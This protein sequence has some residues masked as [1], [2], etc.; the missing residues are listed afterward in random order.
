[1]P[2]HTHAAHD[3]AW[4]IQQTDFAGSS[5]KAYEGLFAQGAPGLHI[6]GSLEEPIAD[7][8]QGLR[9]WRTPGNVTAE[10]FR[11]ARS[12]FG[13]YLPGIYGSHP[14]L[15]NELVNLPW[16][17]W[18]VPE[19][20]GSALDADSDAVAE[21]ERTLDLRDNTLVR[22]L[23]W[24]TPGGARVSLLYER[25]VSM[26]AGARGVR[27]CVQRLTID[28]D[29]ATDV[30]VRAGIDADV[31]TNG[32]DHFKRV[33]LAAEGERVR[34]AVQTD[35]GDRVEIE[36]ILLA[37]HAAEAHAE[38]RRGWSEARAQVTPG[39]PLV[40]EK[41]TTVTTS[42]DAPDGGGTGELLEAFAGAGFD[43][44]HRAH[45]D[46]WR[47]KWAHADVRIQ[48]DDRAQLAVRTSIAHLLRTL[49]HASD[50]VAI[51]A[52]GYAG[53]AYWGRFFWDTE[54]YLLPF[55]LYTDPA[56]ARALADFRIH[57]LEGAQRNAHKLGLP[58][59]KYAW[60]SDQLGDECCPN[61]QYADHEVHITSDVVYGL[62]HV[63]RATGDDSYLDTHA[64]CVL[65][66]AARYW[67]ARVSVRPGDDHPSILGVM[68]PDEYTPI[69]DNNAYTNRLASFALEA[70]ADA[71]A[72]TGQ[73]RDEARTWR[74]LGRTLPIHRRADGLVL[75]SD[76]FD[77]LPLADFDGRWKD[78]TRPFASQAPQEYLYR[79]QCLKQADV[80]M[81]MWLFDSEFSIED[82]RTA[83]RYYEPRTTHDSSLSAAI[84]SMMAC[85][86]GLNEE[87]WRFWEEACAID[88]DGGA[89]EG[90]HIAACGAVWQMVV[91]GFA[92]MRSAMEDEVLTLDP[93]LPAGWTTLEF[94]LVWRG[95]SVQVRVTKDGV[96]LRHSGAASLSARVAGEL[97]EIPAGGVG[98]WA[99]GGTTAP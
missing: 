25:F 67:T 30:T 69:A 15:N 65:F 98:R 43:D 24:R 79:T 6:R 23:T 17:L 55:Y 9:Y 94:P 81:L 45:A 46:A 82:Q 54:M 63:A 37:P 18:L 83:W 80:L 32:Y 10:V 26:D 1:M 73:C 92:G 56:G 88:L 49:P 27:L 31:T 2:C 90:I 12:K 59:A 33:D 53:E 93:R 52:K 89:A 76:A 51:D 44:L 41:R 13:T 47:A 91:F 61:W 58:G 96:E 48:G 3:P 62:A 21:H 60:E 99:T 5:L 66:D 14:I 95:T 22:A 64:A 70:A 86:L 75:Q 38:G 68:G 97:R 42:R 34:C 7:A 78:R 57:S 72:R 28:T 36:S 71:A 16:F 29:R 74:E 87:A 84:H 8:P 50:R 20:D 40:I 39:T 85:R 4:C 19:I 77:R 11:E 35:L